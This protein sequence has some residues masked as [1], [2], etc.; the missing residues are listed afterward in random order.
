MDQK[1]ATVSGY[2]NFERVIKQLNE[3]GFDPVP[4]EENLDPESYLYPDISVLLGSQDAESQL[5]KDL[6]SW[7]DSFD[8]EDLSNHDWASDEKSG[9]ETLAWYQPISNFG[10]NAGIF[11]TDRGIALYAKRIRSVLKARSTAA[12]DTNRVSTLGAIYALLNHEAFHHDFEWFAIKLA[13]TMNI[14]PQELY[15]RYQRD[16]YLRLR[17]P[18]SDDLVE[19]A[20]ASAQEYRKFSA[21]KPPLGLSS[22][23][24]MGIKEQLFKSYGHRPPGYR[25]GQDHLSNG[26]FAWGINTLI[27]QL[28][29]GSSRTSPNDSPEKF[30][31]GKGKFHNY[32]SDNW[33]LVST[34]CSVNGPRKP[35][36][37]ALT[38]KN[39]SL[40][41]FLK[42]HG[43]APTSRGKGSHRVWES[44]TGQIVTLPHRTDQ[45]GYRALK[46]IATVFGLA[47]ANALAK[48][49]FAE[50]HSKK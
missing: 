45:E 50:T 19:E 35:P 29:Q 16:V 11:V 25:C 47:S 14:A 24:V 46:S 39:S 33:T 7:L 6:G 34:N 31:I 42:G 28:V 44:T 18:L 9:L 4:F 30:P 32:F 26:A 21:K 15:I 41:A 43:F 48:E 22:D 40:E 1:T 8:D 5:E 38:V 49:I 27:A 2:T 23:D 13:S 20:L 12:W 36:P 17:N 3:Y 10:I 37:F